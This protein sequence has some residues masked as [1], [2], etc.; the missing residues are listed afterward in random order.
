MGA[1][2]AIAILATVVGMLSLFIG[3]RYYRKRQRRHHNDIPPSFLPVAVGVGSG[4]P[5]APTAQQ[6]VYHP[7]PAAASPASQLKNPIGTPPVP[8][9]TELSTNPAFPAHHTELEAHTRT[10]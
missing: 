8:Q 7:L 1:I 5:Q 4:L 10:F 9:V 3:W 2:I 6:Y